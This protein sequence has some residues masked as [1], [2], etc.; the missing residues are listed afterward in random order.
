[1]LT[2]YRTYA[3]AKIR[4][5]IINLVSLV[6]FLTMTNVCLPLNE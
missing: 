1:M 3:R 5:R 6:H 2:L 4:V